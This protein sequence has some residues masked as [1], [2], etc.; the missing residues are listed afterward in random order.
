MNIFNPSTGQWKHLTNI[1]AARSAPAV[2]GV[3]DNIIVIGGVTNDYEYSYTECMD[4]C[5]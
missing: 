1:L 4:W 3:T 5:V 2:V